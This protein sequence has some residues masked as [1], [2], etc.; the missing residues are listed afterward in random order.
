MGILSSSEGH[1]LKYGFYL[2]K[3]SEL[4]RNNTEKGDGCHKKGGGVRMS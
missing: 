2:F 3:S 4:F 1:V